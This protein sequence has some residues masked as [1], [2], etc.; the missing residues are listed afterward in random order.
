MN[1]QQNRVLNAR[2]LPYHERLKTTADRA[3]VGRPSIWGNPFRSG[4]DGDV[5]AVIA[6][7]R[8]WVTQNRSLMA[9]LPELAGRDLVCWCAPEPCH[10]DVLLELVAQHVDHPKTTP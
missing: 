8:D 9:R 3:Y 1:A 7:Y 10:A 2:R 4:R 6:R 5:T